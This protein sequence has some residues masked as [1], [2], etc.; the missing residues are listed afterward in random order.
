MLR[1]VQERFTVN[2][3]EMPRQI[4]TTSHANAGAQSMGSLTQTRRK[5]SLSTCPSVTGLRIV[6]FLG[7]PGVAHAGNWSSGQPVNSRGSDPPFFDGGQRQ[8]QNPS[9]LRKGEE[10]VVCSL[11]W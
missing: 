9:S 1:N 2:M 4:D 5:I 7:Q 10:S 3:S 8:G 11:R 6:T